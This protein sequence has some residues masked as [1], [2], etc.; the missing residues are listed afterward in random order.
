VWDRKWWRLRGPA[1]AEDIHGRKDSDEIER[2]RAWGEVGFAPDT[3]RRRGS[4]VGV[5]SSY[6]RCEALAAGVLLATCGYGAALLSASAASKR[7]R[8]GSVVA[9]GVISNGSRSRGAVVSMGE[10][11]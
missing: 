1:E 4:K 3:C 9:G 6:S 2:P 5:G 7:E 11:T 8:R 10:G